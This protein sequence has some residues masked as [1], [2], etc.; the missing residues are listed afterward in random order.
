MQPEE[1]KNANITF[2]K[3]LSPTG[4]I[5]YK[6]AGHLLVG[7]GLIGAILPLMPTT[8]FLILAAACYA[9]SSPRFYNWLINNKYFGSQVKNYREHKA[10]PINAKITAITIL[11]ITIALT[12][13][14]TRYD[15]WIYGVL[16]LI[17]AGVTVYLVKIK[18]LKK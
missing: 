13:L 5:F 3:D 7:L 17:A 10:M 18:T 2:G 12:I 14:F 4:K 15:F 1:S 9:K 8:I 11:W 16:L 6:L